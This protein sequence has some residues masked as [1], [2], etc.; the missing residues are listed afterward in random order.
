MDINR[1]FNIKRFNNQINLECKGKFG[2]NGRSDC[3]ESLDKKE[4]QTSIAV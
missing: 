1:N 4:I 2:G 3:F